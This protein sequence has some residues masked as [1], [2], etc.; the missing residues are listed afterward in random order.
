MDTKKVEALMKV[1]ETGS[2]TSAAEELVYSQTGLTNMMNSLENELGITLLSRG[3]TG[4]SL[5]S[6]GYE[7]LPQ[8]QNLLSSS[9][10]VESRLAYIKEKNSTTFRVGAYS[11]VARHWLPAIL[12]RYKTSSPDTEMIF[13][14]QDITEAYNVV[15][16]G[17]ID[18]SIVSYQKNLMTGLKWVP[19]RDDPLVAVLPETYSIDKETFPL[20][21]FADMEFLVPSGGWLKDYGPIFSGIKKLPNFRETNLDDGTIASMISHGLGVSIMSKLVMQGISENVAAVPI[22]PPASRKLGIIYKANTPNEKA[23]KRF[24]ATAKETLELI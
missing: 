15:K 22:D 10:A 12:E 18:C 11:S 13:S 4:V 23:V 9:Q 24:I 6:A 1:L 19:L 3:K 21:N 16:D 5:T 8:L 17:S 7:L 2:L 20:E 14:S